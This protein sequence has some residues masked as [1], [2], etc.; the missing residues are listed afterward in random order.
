MYTTALWEN[1]YSNV[2]IDA[3]KDKDNTAVN[4]SA[5]NYI[6]YMTIKHF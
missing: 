4:D 5:V 6:E 1:N 3:N 2:S